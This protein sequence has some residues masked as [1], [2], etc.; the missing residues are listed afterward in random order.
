[1]AGESYSVVGNASSLFDCSYG[2]HIDNAS[3]V[4][5][6]NGGVIVDPEAQ[7]SRTDIIAFSLYRKAL[8]HFPK[9]ERWDL[10]YCIERKML[11]A[12]YGIKPSNGLIVLKRLASMDCKDV[13]IFGFDWKRTPT[14]YRE[15]PSTPEHHDYALEEKLCRELIREREWKHLL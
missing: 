10:R 15:V 6:F 1:M 5:R 9:C 2:Q 7:G 13:R 14:W 8:N 3:K 11:V 12:Q 4:I